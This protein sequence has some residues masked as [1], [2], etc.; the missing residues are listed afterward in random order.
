M[1][2]VRTGRPFRAGLA[3]FRQ[4]RIALIVPNF[5]FIRAHRAAGQGRM[6]RLASGTADGNIKHFRQ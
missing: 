3:S 5:R 1:G 4:H 6:M 2:P